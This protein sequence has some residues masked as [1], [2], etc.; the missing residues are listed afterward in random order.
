[1][2][3]SM[4]Q[5]L[6][7]ARQITKFTQRVLPPTGVC[8]A[9]NAVHGLRGLQ[10]HLYPSLSSRCLPLTPPNTGV[11]LL[12]ISI[13]QLSVGR[14]DTDHGWRPRFLPARRT[15]SQRSTRHL[16]CETPLIDR[17]TP[18]P[19]PRRTRRQP[20]SSPRH[21]DTSCRRWLTSGCN[22][23]LRKNPSGQRRPK[24]WVLFLWRVGA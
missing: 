1:M 3:P 12:H 18:N 22:L 5:I 11:L 23:Q 19:F 14:R 2:T 21:I 13:P 10:V 9:H 4:N 24:R 7:T 6:P 8:R 20:F 17:D 15:S 16:Q